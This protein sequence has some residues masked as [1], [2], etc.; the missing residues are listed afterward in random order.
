MVMVTV[1]VAWSENFGGGLWEIRREV[2]L[3]R[4]IRDQQ[5]DGNWAIEIPGSRL[6]DRLVALWP[7]FNSIARRLG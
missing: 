4:V 5:W 3:W 7:P 1:V 2:V 6:I